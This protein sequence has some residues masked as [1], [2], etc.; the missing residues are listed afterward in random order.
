MSCTEFDTLNDL[1][2]FLSF[3]L[4]AGGGDLIC[5]SHFSR[6]LC[7]QRPHFSA[8]Q[9][10]NRRRRIGQVVQTKFDCF[11][12]SFICISSS[13]MLLICFFAFLPGSQL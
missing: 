13:F 6:L 9:R 4:A 2:K 7:Q 5:I 12:P 1:I 11:S 3:L 8:A 10:I